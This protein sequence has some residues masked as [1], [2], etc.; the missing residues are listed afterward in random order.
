MFPQMDI[1]DSAM[2]IKEQGQII[3]NLNDLYFNGEIDLKS[4]QKMATEVS[5]EYQK[6]IK[7]APKPSLNKTGAD[8]PRENKPNES[9]EQ[10]YCHKYGYDMMSEDEK[11]IFEEILGQQR[12]N[13]QEKIEQEGTYKDKMFDMDELFREEQLME[14]INREQEE[15][16]QNHRRHM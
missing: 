7:S 16:H 2:L 12:D 5:K 11:K 8:N 13:E 15:I 14:E 4:K 3:Q 1:K 10:E 6:M 9:K